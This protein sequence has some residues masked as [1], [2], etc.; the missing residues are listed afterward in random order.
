MIWHTRSTRP[1]AVSDPKAVRRRA[2]VLGDVAA[3]G[4]TGAFRVLRRAAAHDPE[5][6]D[7]RVAALVRAVPGMGVVDAHDVMIRAGIREGRVLGELGVP[8]RIALSRLIMRRHRLN[9][10]L[11]QPA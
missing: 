10:M 4:A 7:I 5:V 2:A 1:A 3:E 11:R 9:R 8:E 6:C